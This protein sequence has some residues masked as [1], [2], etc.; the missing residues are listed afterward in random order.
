MVVHYRGNNNDTILY[1][2]YNYANYTIV[3]HITGVPTVTTVTVVAE[4]VAS[5]TEA[6]SSRLRINTE[7]FTI[8]V[9]ITTQFNG[10]STGVIATSQVSVI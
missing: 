10:Y 4:M 1:T 9:A 8:L 7:V 2:I 3:V 5:A 6:F